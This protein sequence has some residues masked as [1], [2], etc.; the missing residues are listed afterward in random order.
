MIKKTAKKK[1]RK[2]KKVPVKVNITPAIKVTPIDR[3]PSGIPGL[4][5]LIGGG[6]VK[7]SM[8]LLTGVTGDRKSVV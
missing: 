2:E 1:E 6:L 4:D 3:I 7:K 8:T 5:N